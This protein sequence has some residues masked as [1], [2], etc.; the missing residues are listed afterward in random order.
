MITDT[1][2]NT[3]YGWFASN[4]DK[5]VNL[6][7]ATTDILLNCFEGV[8]GPYNPITAEPYEQLLIQNKEDI[9]SLYESLK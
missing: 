9:V 5:W 3:A 2:L 8:Q 7:T 1:Q 4:F 6:N